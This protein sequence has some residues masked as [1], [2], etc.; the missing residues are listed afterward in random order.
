MLEKLIGIIALALLCV[1]L[2]LYQKYQ[3]QLTRTDV[4][5]VFI[6]SANQIWWDWIA[7][8]C[9]KFGWWSILSDDNYGKYKFRMLVFEVTALKLTR[10]EIERTLN[11]YAV[12]LGYSVRFKVA[13]KKE[14]ERDIVKII[15]ITPET[16]EDY[17]KF[18]RIKK[19][20]TARE[21]KEKY[22][23]T[24]PSGPMII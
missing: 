24:K 12:I 20:Q 19:E 16:A 17:K 15:Y 5:P 11:N 18:V 14:E 9:D 13:I 21:E 22:S 6:L 7:D 23:Y 2:W 10:L 3:E 1:L 4:E 8:H